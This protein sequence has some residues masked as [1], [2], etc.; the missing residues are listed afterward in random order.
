RNKNL[1]GKRNHNI[2]H[3]RSDIGAL[4]RHPNSCLRGEPDSV[5]ILIQS[6][7][8]SSC[9]VIKEGK[10]KQ[11][12]LLSGILVWEVLWTDNMRI[13]DHS[14]RNSPNGDVENR[15]SRPQGEHKGLVLVFRVTVRHELGNLE[16]VPDHS[17]NVH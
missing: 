15:A 7:F 6:Q 14:P 16:T 12:T 10:R 5:R 9:F 13:C 8:L 17:S 1:I 3:I 11:K 4:R 2:T